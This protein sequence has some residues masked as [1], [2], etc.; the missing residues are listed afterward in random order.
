[1]KKFTFAKDPAESA[2]LVNENQ[3]IDILSIVPSELIN[4]VRFW[5]ELVKI[6]PEYWLVYVPEQFM[7]EKE[8]WD[9][10]DRNKFYL[11]IPKSLVSVD[12]YQAYQTYQA[13]GG[14]SYSS[15]HSAFKN[16][17]TKNC[18]EWFLVE[19]PHKYFISKENYNPALFVSR[20]SCGASEDIHDDFW[21]QELA[22]A[23][24]DSEI[25]LCFYKDIPEVFIR[26]E[27]K[28]VI[29]LY[30]TKRLLM[31]GEGDS[32]NVRVENL[33][34]YWENFTTEQEFDDAFILERKIKLY[35]SSRTK[36]FF[37][38]KPKVDLTDIMTKVW[39]GLS[40]KNQEI[41]DSLFEF[42]EIPFA[43]AVSDEFF[44]E[45]WIV[46]SIELA[47]SFYIFN[48]NDSKESTTEVERLEFMD[49]ANSYKKT[50]IDTI[51]QIR[52]NIDAV[53]FFE[54]LII[55]IANN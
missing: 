26:P 47:L 53:Q 21:S 16:F 2:K 41:V 15:Y 11:S 27:W 40:I 14:K 39:N 44:K 49:A 4:D 43:A 50:C 7:S 1:M 22:D 28:R 35:Y 8:L 52:P 34:A 13:N 19:N 36:F 32:C 33:P 9:C 25:F 12:D 24:W 45:E 17:S 29:F 46:K 6:N 54:E 3:S 37:N 20:L 38:S 42:Y 5:I 23:F 51:Q 48:M 30:E 18:Y 10:I 31:L 55:T